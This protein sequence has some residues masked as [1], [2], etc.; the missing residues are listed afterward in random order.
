[1]GVSTDAIVAF[2]VDLGEELPEFLEDFDD[3]FDD[4][5]ASISGLPQYGEPGHSWDA[6]WAFAER[7]PVTIIHHCSGE[8]PM[9]ILAVNGTEQRA[10]RG[11]PHTLEPL[12]VTQEQIDKLRDFMAEH[13]LE[14]EPAWLLFSNWG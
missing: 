13:E 1:M 12:T 4:Y 5:L 10:S 2:G 14:G 8:Y 3:G 9:Y 6:H 7:F 11:Y